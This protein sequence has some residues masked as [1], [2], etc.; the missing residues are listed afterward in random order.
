[1]KSRKSRKMAARPKRPKRGERVIWWRR[2]VP[3]L[4]AALICGLL[5]VSFGTG[6]FALREVEF[7]GGVSLPGDSL[8]VIKASLLGRNMLTVSLSAIR[9]RM[10]QF[11]EIRDV[12]FKR[13]LMGRIDCYLLQRKP[14]ALV[15]GEQLVEIDGEGIVIPRHAGDANIDLPV[16]TGLV[17]EELGAPAGRVAL[18][19]AL[20]V[21][22]LLNE[23]GF[24]PAKQLSEIH[25]EGDE[26]M[27]VLLRT[28]TLVR[29]GSEDFSRRIRKLHA[30]YEALDKSERFPELIDLRFDRQVVVR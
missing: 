20:E 9:D 14:V 17:T 30:V 10:L 18:S 5:Y 6:R 16:V 13:R 3:V 7:H 25:V 27:L 28:G 24:S 22:R 11:P 29:L 1:M 19:K 8:Q 2:I 15:A 21:L 26:I 23:Y 12:I 4:V